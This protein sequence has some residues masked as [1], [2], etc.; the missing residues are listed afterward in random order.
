MELRFETVDNLSK[1][2]AIDFVNETT[3]GGILECFRENGSVV[4]V[5]ST[6]AV[7]FMRLDYLQ[8]MFGELE[9][10]HLVG[11]FFESCNHTNKVYVNYNRFREKLADA[12]LSQMF[13]D[14]DP[15]GILQLLTDSCDDVCLFKDEYHI[16]HNDKL[17]IFKRVDSFILSL[18]NSNN[19]RSNGLANY[20]EFL[21]PIHNTRA[22]YYVN[23][24]YFNLMYDIMPI[25][26]Y[27]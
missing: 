21:L 9:V 12:C 16:V 14:T 26:D 18:H 4:S 23:T 13:I 24:D 2:D 11:A 19:E 7:Y 8:D 5:M 15:Y 10:A 1:Y 6:T 17:Y 27:L 3:W 22:N 25:L 20:L